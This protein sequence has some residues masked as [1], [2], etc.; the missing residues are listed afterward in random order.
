MSGSYQYGLKHHGC[1]GM[2]TA[3]PEWEGVYGSTLDTIYPE[4]DTQDANNLECCLKCQANP[5]C[6]AF[7]TSSDGGSKC[8]LMQLWENDDRYEGNW[9]GNSTGRS[10]V[11]SR[12]RQM[13]EYYVFG[14][15]QEERN[16]ECS[17]QCEEA[18][19][20]NMW[21]KTTADRACYLYSATYATGVINFFRWAANWIIDGVVDVMLNKVM[22][23]ACQKKNPIMQLLEKL[24]DWTQWEVHGSGT[25][26]WKGL[27]ADFWKTAAADLLKTE[28]SWEDLKLDAPKS[29]IAFKSALSEL[30][31]LVDLL[32]TMFH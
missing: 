21:V 26:S 12:G 8:W 3:F 19:D 24:E 22:K 30:Q 16:A 14:D 23:H 29:D 17:Q 18:D 11:T 25:V 9:K 28:T 10:S 6:D 27:A 32:V 4:G 15:T 1:N 2:L 20:C 5:D 7:E 13:G 31:W